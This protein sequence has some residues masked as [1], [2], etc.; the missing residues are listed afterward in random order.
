MQ[1][2]LYHIGRI[3]REA[4]AIVKRHFDH[5]NQSEIHKKGTIDLVTDADRETEAFIHEKLQKQFPDI[6]FL[7]E[8]TGGENGKGAQV[9]VVDP[10]D[11]T[12]SFVHGHPFHSVS[13]AYR[14]NGKSMAGAVYL[15]YFDQLYWAGKGAGAWKDG[16]RIH[17]SKTNELINALGATGFGCVRSNI[18]P[19]NVPAIADLLYKLQ[20][21]RRCGS[22]AI[23]LCYVAEG[24]YDTYWE[25]HI[26]PWDWAAGKIIVEEAGGIVTGFDGKEPDDSLGRILSSNG[27]LHNTMLNEIAKH[28]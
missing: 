26:K 13:I 25:F 22:A 1:T 17:V 5:L 16:K 9:F 18:K 4:G 23:D 24:R 2:I 6:A 7:G 11:G 3:A 8:E 27:L 14:E 20:G 28:I 15:P 12:T 21:V 19:D 10:I